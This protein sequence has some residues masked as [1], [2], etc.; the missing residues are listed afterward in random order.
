MANVYC[1]ITLYSGLP[2]D[3]DK[4]YVIDNMDEF[5]A[6]KLTGYKFIH[7]FQIQ[8]FELYKTIKVNASQLYAGNSPSVEGYKWNYCLIQTLDSQGNSLDEY[9]YFVIGI[10]QKAQSTVELELKMDVLNT[11]KYMGNVGTRSYTLTAKTLVNREHKNRFN[12]NLLIDAKPLKN[13]TP[14]A[15]MT[16]GVKTSMFGVGTSTYL[17][18]DSHYK[19][20]I[21]RD[22]YQ[23]TIYECKGQLVA[24]RLSSPTASQRFIFHD[25]DGNEKTISVASSYIS[26][27]YLV[28]EFIDNLE[29]EDN[30]FITALILYEALNPNNCIYDIYCLC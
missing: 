17:G 20:F 2:L 11:F 12:S 29:T 22:G 5:I 18:A 3:P 28:I 24:A 30:N 1:D 27:S 4:N 21:L 19:L 26:S 13:H 23:G 16:Y 7:N 25:M 6:E 15:N 8:R 9:Y 14:E 10:H